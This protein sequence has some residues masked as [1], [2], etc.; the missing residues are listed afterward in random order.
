MG[1]ITI[2]SQQKPNDPPTV[3]AGVDQTINLPDT[4]VSLL[5]T[6]GDADGI[7]V[8]V[9]WTKLSGGTAVFSSPST[10]A[11]NVTGLQVGNYTFQVKVTDN[12]GDIAT[13]TVVIHVG[14]YLTLPFKWIG[15]DPECVEVMGD[16]T[17]YTKY[18]TLLKVS[19]DVNEYPLDVNNIR[20]SLSGDPQD[21]KDNDPSDLDYIAN[22]LNLGDCPVPAVSPK[23][24]K[25]DFAP[26]FFDKAITSTVP[27]GG[28][29]VV[30]SVC[31]DTQNESINTLP[32]VTQITL[33]T[34]GNGR[35]LTVTE[36]GN[37]QIDV[38][39]NGNLR[40]TSSQNFTITVDFFL[41]INGEIISLSPQ[42]PDTIHFTGL[43]PQ[44][45]V[46]SPGGGG[47]QVADIDYDFDFSRL[48]NLLVGA[49]IN[50]YAEVRYVSTGGIHTGT[51]RIQAD[52]IS[53][54]IKQQ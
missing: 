49:Y 14:N 34:T 11:T 18:N 20:T 21:S 33:G 5:A 35:I 41:N 17:G 32:G 26:G 40:M 37:H 2:I 9:L 48:D 27:G 7:I 54:D 23:E 39:A 4:S 19:D 13:D 30:V 1:T 22:F 38:A 53:V 3:N 50:F 15:D 42:I 43:S 29:P 16:N 45:I 51:L 44:Y 6:A 25:S 12:S 24:F 10:L 31:M 8:S 28:F 52:V 46:V 47:T 36:G